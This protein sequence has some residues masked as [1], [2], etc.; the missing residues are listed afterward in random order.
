MDEWAIVLNDRIIKRFIIEEGQSLTIGRGQESDIVVVNTAISR[1]HCSLEL[2][3]GVYYLTDLYSLNGTQ[4]NGQKVVSA[5]PVEKTDL[6]QVSK[7]ILQPSDTILAEQTVESFAI[8][9]DEELDKTIFITAKSAQ[10]S[11]PG[12]YHLSVISGKAVPEKLAL[13]GRTS[14]KVGKAKSCDIVISGLLL[15]K[16]QFFIT[17]TPRHLTIIPQD[18]FR[19]TRLN[20]KKIKK[21]TNL[22]VGD[23]ISAGGVSFKFA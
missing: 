7:F 16:T 4:V 11:K 20:G 18:G 10:K 5:V 12:Q 2:K 14:I 22:R 6:I 19:K 13:T 1:Q 9:R 23:I 3:G 17:R 8:S 15:G 21:E